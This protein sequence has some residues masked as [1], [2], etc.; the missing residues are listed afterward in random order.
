IIDAL[1]KSVRKFIICLGGSA[2]NDAGMGLLKALGFKFFDKNK[3]E[4]D[5]GGRELLKLDS[6]NDSN[7]HSAIY[8]SAFQIACDV[9]NPLIG[10]DGASA[11]FGP[12]KGASKEMVKVLDKGL[13]RFGEIVKKCK[14][15]TIN[16]IPGSGAAGGTAG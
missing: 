10:N 1:N 14:G 7:V 13:K 5:H 3:K 15:V 11:V 12:Q 6:I 8:D 2:T 16:E 4:L 9:N